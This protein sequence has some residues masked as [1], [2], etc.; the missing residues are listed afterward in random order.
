MKAL[1]VAVQGALWMLTS[2]VCYVGSATLIR[3]IGEDYSPFLLTFFRAVIAVIMLAPLMFPV[4]I[5]SLWPE[6]PFAVL[7]TG[8]ISYVGIFLWFYSAGRMPVAEFFALQ[9][10]TPLFTIAFAIIFL[11]ERSD[12]ASWI[13]TF[14]GF[15][16]VLIVLRPGLIA[17][18]VAAIAAI[19]CAASYASVNTIIKSLSSNVPTTVIVFYA[20]F[21]LL[22]IS[23]P[24]AIVDWQAPLLADVPAIVGAAVLSTIGYLTVSKGIAMAAARVVQPVNFLRMPIAAVFGWVLFSEFPDIWTWIGAIVIF[25]ATTY[26]VQRGARKK[27]AA[28]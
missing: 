14:V 5:S 16:G 26:T 4:R 28:T 13:A 10:A 11:R 24:M 8:V 3:Y 9:F 2:A 25:C 17:V 12:I 15:A 7:M 19:A 6:R 22:P 18:S 23:L 27:E 20:N 1:P 21:L